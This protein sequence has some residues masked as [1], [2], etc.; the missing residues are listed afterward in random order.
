MR[1]LLRCGRVRTWVR[2]CACSC[3]HERICV[4]VCVRVCMC[5]HVCVRVHVHEGVGWEGAHARA[6]VR[7]EQTRRTPP[8]Y[9]KLA[10]STASTCFSAARGTDAARRRVQGCPVPRC[11]APC[12]AVIPA[13]SCLCAPEPRGRTPLN[14]P[15]TAARMC[16][17]QG[18][19]RGRSACACIL[20]APPG[21][22]SS[23]LC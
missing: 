20:Q 22:A 6:H 1:V 4:P 12:A 11:R 17:M 3:L 19:G 2:A 18:G 16:L 15:K 13:C 5:A 8:I 23:C 7:F 21:L 10:G 14:H 9:C